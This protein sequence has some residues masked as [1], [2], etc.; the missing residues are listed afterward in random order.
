[1]TTQFNRAEWQVLTAEAAGLKP[2]QSCGERNRGTR[3]YRREDGTF[4]VSHHFADLHAVSSHLILCSD[5]A[6]DLMEMDFE[7]T[8]DS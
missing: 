3:I 8:A 2:G 4:T 5:Y 1:M 7:A 6:D